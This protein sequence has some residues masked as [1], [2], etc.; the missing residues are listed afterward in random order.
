M[1]LFIIM[2][3][4]ISSNTIKWWLVVFDDI[5]VIVHPIN[6]SHSLRPLSKHTFS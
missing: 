4:A 2:M 5:Q 1:K 3:K 6:F